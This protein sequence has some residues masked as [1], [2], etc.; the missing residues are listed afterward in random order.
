MGTEI[1]VSSSRPI[2]LLKGLVY[3]QGNTNGQVRNY[4]E[5]ERKMRIVV[6]LWSDMEGVNRTFSEVEL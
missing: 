3:D 4:T 2:R 1:K 6:S 5:R